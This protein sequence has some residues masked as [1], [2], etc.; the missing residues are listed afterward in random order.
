MRSPDITRRKFV[1]CGALFVPAALGVS[2]FAQ[3]ML[4]NRR[5][6]FRS[7]GFSPLDVAGCQLWLKADAITGLANDDPVSTWADLSGLGH[8]A[9]QTLTQRPIYKTGILNG[10]PVVRFQGTNDCMKGVLSVTATTCTVFATMAINSSSNSGARVL[11]LGLANTND[12]TGV[13]YVMA[14]ARSGTTTTM[15]SYR[16]GAKSGVT[17]SYGTFAVLTSKYDGTNHTMYKDGVAG[18]P[19]SSTGTFVVSD[20]KI[21]SSLNEADTSWFNGDLLELLV[22]STSLSTGN[23]QAVEDYMGGRGAITITH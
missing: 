7:V 5:K 22:Y 6:A 13:N 14:L 4:Q 20:Y 9:A 2:A 18:T 17:I 19:V 8:D 1:K 10:L 12:Y 3:P 23:Q 16:N 15:F 21:G 11:S